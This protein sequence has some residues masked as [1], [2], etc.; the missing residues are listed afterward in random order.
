MLQR[1][2]TRKVILLSAFLALG[3]G[4]FIFSQINGFPKNKPVSN[5]YPAA[6]TGTGSGLVG[7][8]KFDE[9]SGTV[10]ADSSGNANNGT[11]LN[12]PA[13]TQGKINGALSFDGS[14]DYV[15][16]GNASALRFENT[17]PFTLSAWYKFNVTSFGAGDDQGLIA[18][19]NT[20]GSL[21][22]YKLAIEADAA[23]DPWSFIMRDINS[24]RLE[25]QFPRPNNTDWHYISVIYDGSSNASG[26]SVYIDGMSQPKTVITNTLSVS[27]ANSSP[28]LVGQFFGDYFDGSIDEV[29]VYNRALSV[30]EITE[31]FNAA[32]AP[33]SPSTDTQAPSIPQNL[34]ASVFSSSQ[35][36]LSW[37]ASTDNVA[38]TG[39]RIYRSGTQIATSNTTSFQNTGLSPATA[40]FYTVAAYDAAGNV[41]NQ[42]LSSSAT[43]QGVVLP[44]SPS[45]P[46]P[47]PPLDAAF[48]NQ[49]NNLA[50]NS[51]MYANPKTRDVYQPFITDNAINDVIA[52]NDVSRFNCLRK[53]TQGEPVTRTFTGIT[54]GNGRIFYFGG[55]HASH[56]GNDVDLYTIEANQ[57]QEEYV[58]ECP[59]PGSAE[60]RGIVGSGGAATTITPQNRPYHQHMY[61]NCAYDAGRNRF[62]CVPASGTW[63]FSLNTKTWSALAGLTASPGWYLNKGLVIF[64]PQA[65]KIFA[66][67]G[68]ATRG[69]RGLHS[70][71]AGTNTWRLEAQK[72]PPE[73]IRSYLF[74]AYNKDRREIFVKTVASDGQG[75]S[76]FYRVKIPTGDWT[77]VTSVPAELSAS[78][79]REFDYDSRNKRMVFLVTPASGREAAVW[80]W[81]MD[82]DQ[83]VKLPTAPSAPLSSSNGGGERSTFVYDEKTNAFVY[84]RTERL[85]CGIS[86]ASCGGSMKT[87]IYRSA[88]TAQNPPP[89]PPPPQSLPVVSLSADPVAIDGKG[90]SMLSW[91]VSG[92]DSCNALGG[93]T[94]SRAFSG[95]E[96]TGVLSD[97]TS[98]TLRCVNARGSAE[99]SVIVDVLDSQPLPPPAAPQ[100]SLTS[101]ADLNTY[102]LRPSVASVVRGSAVPLSLA[103][104]KGTNNSAAIPGLIIQYL[105]DGQPIS[106]YLS[107]PFSFSWDST[108]VAD[109]MYA[110]GVRL[111]DGPQLDARYRTLTVSVVVDNVAGAVS[112]SQRLPVA[113][114]WWKVFSPEKYLSSAL[115]WVTYPG[116]FPH[117]SALHP[118]P[119]KFS[120][121]AANDSERQSLLD[122]RNWYLEALTGSQPDLHQSNPLFVRI[123]DGHLRISGFYQQNDKTS[124]IVGDRGNRYPNFD[125]PRNDNNVSPYSTFVPIP[126]G[127]GWMGIDLYG[128]LFRIDPNGTVTT[129]A[130]RR[131]RRDTLPYD[132]YYSVA[133]S[134]V[135]AYQTELVGNFSGGIDFDLPIDLV[136]DPRDPKIIYV[137]DTRRDRIA[138][139]DTRQNP[140]FVTTYAGVPNQ[141]GLVDGPRLQ[142][143]FNAPFSLVMSSDG[144]MYVADET[145]SAIRKINPDGMVTT[146][147][148][149]G[150]KAQKVPDK[151]TL[152]NNRQNFTQNGDFDTATINYPQVI[153]FD[154]D[155]NLIVVEYWTNWVRR[156]NLRTQQVERIIDFSTIGSGGPGDWVWL[157]VDTKGLMGPKDDIWLTF[158]EST[159]TLFRVSK[160][161]SRSKRMAR[162]SFQIDGTAAGRF[163]HY[164]W[165]L[166]LDDEE[167]RFITTGFGSTGVFSYRKLLPGDPPL[168][169]S[170][171]KETLY[172]KGREMYRYGTVLSF[173]FDS[174]PSFYNLH[175]PTGWSL[176]GN[177]SNFD[178]MAAMSDGQ[179][180]TYIQQGMGGAVPRPEISGEDLRALKYFIRVES[181]KGYQET[182]DPGVSSIDG[183]PPSISNIRAVQVDATTARVTWN[184][185]EPALGLVKFGVSENY[186][187][188]SDIESDYG[189]THEV[190]LHG[191]PQDRLMHFAVL[192]KDIAGNNTVSLDGTFTMGSGAVFQDTVLP[193]VSL[194][195]PAQDASV[196]GAITINAQASDNIGV[197][198]VQFKL[199]GVLLGAEDTFA[200]YSVSWD[201]S[202]TTNGSHLISAVARDTAGN[203]KTA[204][205]S[206]TVANAPPSVII[207]AI[208]T[209][210]WSNAGTWKS[211][212]VPTGNDK[213]IITGSGIVVTYD[214]PFDTQ[215]G[216]EARAIIVKDG[217]TLRMSRVLSTRLDL[218]G[219]LSIL[220]GGKL[221]VG[222]SVDPIPSALKTYI[223]F[224][225]ANDR[226]FKGGAAAPSDPTFP[227][228]QVDDTGLWVVGTTA[229]ADFF[230]G[231]I[232]KT[233]TKLVSDAPAGNSALSLR[234]APQGWKVGDKIVI[235]PTGKNSDETE[236][237][238]ITAISG[239]RV[240]VNLPLA[241]L[242][243]G[244]LK[245]YN[246]TTQA[247]RTIASESLI[248]AGE[249][250][251]R[252]QG[253]VG[254]LT[255]NVT[256]ASNL[257]REGDTNHRSHVM[258]VHG[259]KGSIQYA[260]FR[261]L[262]PRAT[263]GRYPIHLHELGDAG[264]GFLINGVSVWSSISDPMNKCITIHTSNGV[265]ISNVVG[266]NAQGACFYL[267][268]AKEQGNTLDGN[269]GVSVY[270]P[271]EI[272]NGR[273]P[274]AFGYDSTSAAIFWV[275]EKNTYRN[276]VAAG[277]RAGVAGFWQTPN[278][279]A[280]NALT[281][282]TTNESHS[283]GIGLDYSG[284]SALTMTLDGI[285]IWNNLIGAHA[286]SSISAVTKNSIFWNNQQ[287]I[288]GP[289][290]GTF[291]AN[292]I[293]TPVA[294]PGD[295]TAPSTPANLIA[296]VFSSSQINLSWTASTDNVA[297]TGY[298]IYRGGTQITTVPGTSYSN[299]GLTANTAYSYTVAAVD[300][301]GNVSALSPARNVTTLAS[302]PSITVLL[303]HWKF[304]EGSGI[305]ASDS[306]GN[307]NTGTLT[308]DPLWVTGKSGK[309]LQFDKVDDAVN[310]NA[311]TAFDNLPQLTISAWI[312]PKSAGEESFGRILE[313]ADG[314]TYP[315][316]RGWNLFMT[317]NNQLSFIADF[318]STNLDKRSS[319][320]VLTLNQWQH[321][322]LTWDGSS[323]A[324]GVHF[325][326]NGTEVAYTT[327]QSGSGT[328]VPDDTEDL[329]VGNNESGTR[330]FD[331]AIDEVRVYNRALAQSEIQSLYTYSTGAI[332]FK[333]AN[334]NR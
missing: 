207:E 226:S 220:Q 199:D 291:V 266:F 290:P 307:G 10:A 99:K 40:Y 256:I 301:A 12:G 172:R 214:L 277:G 178:D 125:G 250:L 130:G 105:L 15:N 309:A 151:Q 228:Y 53:I 190:F 312:N 123:N 296:T 112:G 209:G 31:I 324:S 92:A 56:I 120:P 185:N 32:G 83:W 72:N 63:A 20:G 177:V 43:T 7:Y 166:A 258:Y 273:A 97:N 108:K 51:W 219:S 82:T 189:T 69:Q 136:F 188:W 247:I 155:G 230:G 298:R 283:N 249:V 44:P 224:N 211:G 18:K 144:T 111:I 174:R 34:T 218:D 170:G 104:R 313:K 14:D 84:L 248:I 222:T 70:F 119:Y 13:W 77:E 282:F 61:Q 287:D 237:R 116:F 52:V 168:I 334:A 19:E 36:N 217:A 29:R 141:K 42:S 131:V 285:F 71:D 265:T 115:D 236:V 294:L 87:W 229:R 225:V 184:T 295:T 245:A 127:P 28:F 251:L 128:R 244:N 150:S 317:G 50:P 223:G 121:P 297:V 252:A 167:A 21:P 107:S 311:P 191:L 203:Q 173:P 59:L 6:L 103:T 193:Q 76:K 145:N 133:E 232:P 187:R 302:Q 22:G 272:S 319:A 117:T 186:F 227:D 88:V 66:L 268:D 293:I 165:A 198:G 46:L 146:L 333:D 235:T 221:D 259:A 1:V 140:A 55:G 238:T 35:I 45:F 314:V 315:I 27:I 243:E 280:S 101:V 197:L 81:N 98:F 200:P 164:T 205:V 183:V 158:T 4:I 37:T 269:L 96:N 106:P 284:G 126:D 152:W 329:R 271:E 48:I 264:N 286:A 304:D 54:A 171:A 253:E 239:T 68:E 321:V 292:T 160:D 330:T 276:N 102:H 257:V 206:V 60:A 41:S 325:Y 262:G 260:E 137:A 322:A 89:P 246:K 180:T 143:L 204:S 75:T 122:M 213:V 326:V 233:W 300:A 316:T 91:F 24:R 113:S 289:Q 195:A 154:S 8:W 194:I 90:T 279:L 182:I 58:P 11:L 16:M 331:G 181:T 124:E 73:I 159:D 147:V 17:N 93:W 196:S 202:K 332:D 281:L 23:N 134:A 157:E 86:A 26:V 310:I 149:H 132:P 153:R 80:T 129:I 79:S 327:N 62:T 110:F 261:D 148:G 114:D 308:N 288:S 163:G 65:D 9:G 138:K 100:F 2:I 85:Y 162:G 67:V 212:K 306:S 328:R 231:A 274:S 74:G 320:A 3:A 47:D 169:P 254:L 242:H 135:K 234:D 275:R 156:I 255:H 303:A 208:R 49:L 118:F 267:E 240:T 201:T 109:G 176:L 305:T 299:T 139:V 192:A 142:A 216:A 318:A 215:I 270:A 94:G 5:K 263:M 33:P 30:V 210:A 161:G 57:W 39:Y 175:G 241:F 38:V 179:L 25:V 64:D 95:S 323:S 278:V 78:D